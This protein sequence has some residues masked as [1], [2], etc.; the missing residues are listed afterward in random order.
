MRLT[1]Q[2]W[3]GCQIFFRNRIKLWSEVTGKGVEAEINSRH[4]PS[5]EMTGWRTI[6]ATVSAEMILNNKV[7][8]NKRKE[9]ETKERDRKSVV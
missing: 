3:K 1:P 8:K 6:L 5:N 9:Y 4:A 2:Q 7:V